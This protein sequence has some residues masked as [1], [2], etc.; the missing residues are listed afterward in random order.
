MIE[1]SFNG[2]TVRIASNE[3]HVLIKVAEKQD[4]QI[5]SMGILNDVA[6]IEDIVHR[7][8]GDIEEKYL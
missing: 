5:L 7:S 2:E 4:S 1:N 3:N 6:S 8:I